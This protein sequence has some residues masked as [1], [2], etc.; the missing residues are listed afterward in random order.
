MGELVML[1]AYRRTCRN[2]LWHDD[3]KNGACRRPGGWE[4]G[5]KFRR[6]ITFA[7]RTSRP[8]NKQEE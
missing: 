1:D 7:R 2:C 8:E 5:E 6:C 3:T 4:W